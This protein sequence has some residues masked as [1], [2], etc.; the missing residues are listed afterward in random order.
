V[1]A[2]ADTS[3]G[4]MLG[5]DIAV[6]LGR[7]ADGMDQAARRRQKMAEAIRQIPIAPP[8]IPIT[9]GSGALQMA[10]LLM[11][12]TGFNWSLRRLVAF[13]FS[14]G[15]VTVYKNATIAGGVAV[16]GEILVTFPS[17]G[18]DT[19]GRGEMLLM[20]QDQLVFAAT[21]ITLSAGFP[22]V[23]INGAAD[24]FEAWLLPDYLLGS[25][26]I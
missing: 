23:Q 26:F 16:A 10:D 20:E 12:K 8:Q 17:A 6:Q 14:A 21:G 5:G 25:N 7:I 18:T 4:L 15:T 13:G 19:F 24:C 9:A 11:P 22:G 3:T 1:T 2:D